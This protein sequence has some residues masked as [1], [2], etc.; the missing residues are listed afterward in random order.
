MPILQ[1]RELPQVLYN[2]LARQAKKEHRSLAQQAIAEL[3]R[4]LD[5]TAPGRDRRQAVIE[6]LHRWQA[7]LDTGQLK[8]PAAM[9]REDRER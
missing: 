1:V 7:D 6:E 9:I 2:K 5:V 3:S 4:A 8:D